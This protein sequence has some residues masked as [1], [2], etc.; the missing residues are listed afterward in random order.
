MSYL[1]LS[2]HTKSKTWCDNSNDTYF[3]MVQFVPY[4]LYF[5]TLYKMKFGMFL[6]FEFLALLGFR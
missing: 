5:D 1:L 3:C 4:D 2:L 6:E